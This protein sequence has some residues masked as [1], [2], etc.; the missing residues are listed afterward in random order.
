MTV[1]GF[2]QSICFFIL[3]LLSFGFAFAF[4]FFSSEY[5]SSHECRLTEFNVSYKN[6]ISW[7]LLFI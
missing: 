1:R 4:A 6:V 5:Q 7:I 3:F 2:L